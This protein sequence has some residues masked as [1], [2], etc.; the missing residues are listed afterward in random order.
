[1]IIAYILVNLA[2]IIAFRT[3]DKAEFRPV[4]HLLM[5]LGG[6]AIFA[7]PLVGTFYPE[8]AWPYNILP[9][10]AVGWLAVG[11][12]VVAWLARRRP[13]KLAATGKVFVDN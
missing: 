9:Y 8:P 5:P 11:I 10:I 2:L 13:D 7:F 1:V 3:K 4:R 6:I 12:G